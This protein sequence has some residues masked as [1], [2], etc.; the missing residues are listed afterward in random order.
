LNAVVRVQEVAAEQPD[1]LAGSGLD[2]P[3]P[4]EQLATYALELRGWAIGEAEPAV[5]AE[6]MHDGQALR[7]VPLDVSRPRLAATHPKANGRTEIGFATAQSALALPP[8]FELEIRAVLESGG[9]APMALLRGTREP[10]R[11]GF[12]TD[13]QPLMLTTLGI[14]FSTARTVS[15]R[16]VSVVA[17]APG[18]NQRTKVKAIQLRKKFIF[19]PTLPSAKGR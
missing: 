10:V 4:G 19:L 14:T 8:G 9:R 16:L 11:T 12:E 3:A 5:E 17:S 13:L 6:V 18:A 15:S 1:T 2:A 7:R